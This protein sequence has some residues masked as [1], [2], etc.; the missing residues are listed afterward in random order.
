MRIGTNGASRRAGARMTAVAQQGVLHEAEARQ[1]HT[2]V[3]K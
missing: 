1:V 2:A 3:L